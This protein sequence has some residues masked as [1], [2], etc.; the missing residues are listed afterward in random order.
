MPFP[1]LIPLALT[2]ASAIGGALANR[3]KQQTTTQTPTI[4][5]EYGPLQQLLIQRA[6]DKLRNPT[7]LPAGY[8]T[9]GIKT[10]NDTFDTGQQSLENTLSA[11]GLSR[12]PIGGTPLA[13]MQGNRLSSIS[14]FRTNLPLVQRQMQQEDQAG[15]L[16][17]LGMGRGATVTGQQPGDMLGGGVSGLAQML[18]FLY[19]QGAFGGSG[20]RGGSPVSTGMPVRY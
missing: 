15:A 9:G 17:L 14:N 3:K 5:P 11:R 2:A 10:I 4:A 19:G 7:A 6:T 13:R 1:L 18:G 12:S 8:E 16:D 20:G